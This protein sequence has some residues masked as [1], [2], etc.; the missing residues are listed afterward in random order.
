MQ[1]K[2]FI[3]LLYFII[4]AAII[5]L[6]STIPFYYESPSMYYKTGLDKILLRSGKI[7]GIIATILIF[8]QLIFISRF[9]NIEKIFK[10][11]SLFQAH[12]T[13][14][15]ILLVA[16][17]IHPILILGAD[18]FVFFPF[19]LKYWPEFTGIA[20]LLILIT[21]VVISHFQKRIGLDYKLWRWLHKSFAP[22]IIIFVFVH[23]L[24]VSR[25]FE[26]GAP[27]YALIIF[28]ILNLILIVR[29]YLK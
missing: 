27:Y 17:L 10:L 11:K 22:V 6:A 7:L 3:K 5:V 14:G 29:K 12:R 13:N 21:F 8:Y 16:A 19:E 24:N 23:V 1:Q 4:F 20:L 9:K 26:S 25:T 15:I 18:H 28:F 2:A